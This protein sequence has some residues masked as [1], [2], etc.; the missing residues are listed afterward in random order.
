MSEHKS[1]FELLTDDAGE[2]VNY[3][4]RA[5]MMLALRDMIE[6]KGWTQKEAANFLGVTQPRISNL[7]QGKISKF[8]VDMLISMMVKMGFSF[9]FTY[10]NENAGGA[11]DL[12]DMNLSIKVE[13]AH[14]HA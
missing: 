6:M 4:L 8:S 7:K 9:N 1:A 14:A 12:S 13:P 3:D 2:V 5:N 10:A 11:A